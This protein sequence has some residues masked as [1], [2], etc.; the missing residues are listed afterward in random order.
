MPTILVNLEKMEK[1]NNSY[2]I[3]MTGYENRQWSAAFITDFG[4]AVKILHF[5]YAINFGTLKVFI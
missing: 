1:G 3:M 5:L 4:T 2:N